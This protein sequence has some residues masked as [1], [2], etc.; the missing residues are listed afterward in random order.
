MTETLTYP[1]L[2]G[3]ANRATSEDAADSI[4]PRT[5]TLRN[6]VCQLLLAR[7]MTAD[8]CAEWLGE[9]KLS[10]RPRLTEL[11]GLESITDSGKRRRNCSGKKAIVWEVS[12][13]ATRAGAK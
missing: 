9:D 3:F 10:I 12:A 6:K 4:A 13:S 5:E 2:P 1:L 11:V 8:E 7:P